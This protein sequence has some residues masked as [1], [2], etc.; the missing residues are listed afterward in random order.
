MSGTQR[1]RRHKESA[2][3][4]TPLIR[5]RLSRLCGEA[6][7]QAASG[8]PASASSYTVSASWPAARKLSATEA[9]KF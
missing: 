4:L 6:R 7:M 3:R 8:A 9:G 2:R 1:S 5:R